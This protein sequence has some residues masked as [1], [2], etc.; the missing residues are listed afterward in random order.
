MNNEN[1]IS[2]IAAAIAHEVKNPISLVSA[3]IDLMASK[4]T[5][6]IYEKNYLLMRKELNKINK[7]MMDFINLTEIPAYDFFPV[8]IFNIIKFASEPYVDLLQDRIKINIYCKNKDIFVN[9]NKKAL[10]MMISN[11]LKNAV[12]AISGNGFVDIEVYEENSKVSMF[13]KDSGTGISYETS[14]ALGKRYFTTKDSGSGL[15][16]LICKKIAYEHNGFF[17]LYNWERGC[18]A[19]VE[20]PVYHNNTN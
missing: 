14:R 16:V 6:H 1:A 10:E 9:G 7:I 18:I 12:E 13:F 19:K 20:F 17:S 15:G 4:D 8:N 3:N 2:E 5:G 11:I